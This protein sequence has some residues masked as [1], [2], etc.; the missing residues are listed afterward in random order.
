M[1]NFKFFISRP[2]F[3]AVVL[4]VAAF[5]MYFPSLGDL[6]LEDADEAPYGIITREM[7]MTGHYGT[8]TLFGEPW[9]DKPPL[10]FWLMAASAKVFGINE[11]ALRLPSAIFSVVAVLATFWLTFALTASIESSLFAGLV[12]I[13]LPLFLSAARN[14]RMDVQMA[15]IIIGAI[16]FFMRGREKPAYLLGFGV[17]VGLG[18]MMKGVIAGFAFPIALIF[19]AVYNYWGWTRSK[20]FW[21]GLVV[22]L[23]LIAAPW[24]IYEMIKIGP[25]FLTDY[26]V[27][28]AGRFNTN[29][30]HN[31]I[32]NAYLTWV[33]WKF[34]QPWSATLI[35][36]VVVAIFLKRYSRVNVATR[37]FLRLAAASLGSFSFIWFIFY[38]ASSKLVTY[39]IPSYP[40]LAV[41]IGSVYAA[42]VAA[43]NKN[44]VFI[45]SIATCL[46]VLAVALSVREAFIHQRLYISRE[47][48]DFKTIGLLLADR[49]DAHPVY[50]YEN[51]GGPALTY[52]SGKR[53]L[54]LKEGDE[55]PLT[56]SVYIVLPTELIKDNAWLA[57]S[58]AY[59][60]QY[61]SLAVARR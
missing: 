33:F 45:R 4:V 5:L 59:S 19:A 49:Q 57:R 50:L 7:V 26:F 46:V 32:G 18:I 12:L 47:T 23:L 37:Q 61:L 54:H 10:N 27:S 21:L 6:P 41:F 51:S 52:Y 1:V 15:A 11:L 44:S 16:Y 17:A 39:P 58:I 25:D 42:A 43:L 60:G 28:Q 24:H 29:I 38:A 36:S 14:V 3:A 8:L 9:V 40:F 55:L 35:L 48:V 56:S 22:G 34:G 13:F 30:G 53:V 31:G 20:Y 2:W